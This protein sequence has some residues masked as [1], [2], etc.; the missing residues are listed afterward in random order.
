M[1]RVV[2]TTI[3]DLV[4]YISLEYIDILYEK[5][6]TVSY[7]QY[8]EKFLAFLKEFTLKALENFYEYKNNEMSLREDQAYDYDELC[9][10][11]EEEVV[12]NFSQQLDDP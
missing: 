6:K 12:K 8:D 5:I 9:Q 7:Q 10:N 4:P 11:R 2:Y 3:K 1:V